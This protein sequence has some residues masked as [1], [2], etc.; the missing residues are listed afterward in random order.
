MTAAFASVLWIATA[1][2]AGTG[3]WY[4]FNHYGRHLITTVAAAPAPKSTAVTQ[5]SQANSAASPSVPNQPTPEGFD[6]SRPVQVVLTAHDVVWVQVSADGQDAFVGVLHPND[7][8]TIAADDQVKIVTGNAGGLDIS[9]NGKP[10]DPIGSKGQI[11]TVSLTAAG[12][13]VGPQN[14]PASSPL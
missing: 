4:Y 3:A 2:G 1:G 7:T 13:Q 9:L 14:P 6:N 5:V 11:R 12:P 8:R 10:L